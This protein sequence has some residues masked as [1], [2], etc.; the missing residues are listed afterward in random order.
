[1]VQLKISPISPSYFLLS[2][3]HALCQSYFLIFISEAAF[4]AFNS[5]VLTR[6]EAVRFRSALDCGKTALCGSHSG[7]LR[8]SKPQ[9]FFF[10]FT[11]RI[12]S[13]IDFTFPLQ[14]IYTRLPAPL[15][16]VIS[17]ATESFLNQFLLVHDDISVMCIKFAESR[18]P[19]FRLNHSQPLN[20]RLA[21]WTQCGRMPSV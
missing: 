18:P 16:R 21:R 4:S 6:H 12:L 9:G 7:I 19:P 17:Y 5:P 1:M 3:L 8:A 20:D 2:G 11:F 13:R 14:Y 10:S 15:P